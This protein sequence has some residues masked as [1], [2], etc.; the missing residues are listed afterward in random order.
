MCKYSWTILYL[1]STFQ[2]LTCTLADA[3]IWEVASIYSHFVSLSITALHHTS[4][5]HILYTMIMVVS[6]LR[7]ATS[8]N[9]CDIHVMIKAYGIGI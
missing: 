3:C 2:Y 8:E 6:N 7:I 9:L 4:M 5:S 1:Y